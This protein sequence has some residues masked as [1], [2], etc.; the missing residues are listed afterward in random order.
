[1][2]SVSLSCV[3]IKATNLF[4][5]ARTAL[6]NN[7]FWEEGHKFNGVYY[8][9]AKRAKGKGARQNCSNANHKRGRKVVAFTSL[10]KAVGRPGQ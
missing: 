5:S 1:M 8:S 3:A 7:S 10:L 2:T 9:E 6:T 4:L